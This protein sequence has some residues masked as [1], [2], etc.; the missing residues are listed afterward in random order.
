[1][2]QLNLLIY[3]L[4]LILPLLLAQEEQ[5]YYSPCPHD[6]KCTRSKNKGDYSFRRSKS[7]IKY[8][9]DT[10]GNVFVYIKSRKDRRLRN[11]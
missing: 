2:P 6:C 3:S 5:Q 4:A 1:M 11:C 8:E 7:I 10:E 9:Q